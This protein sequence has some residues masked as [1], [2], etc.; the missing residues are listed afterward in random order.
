VVTGVAYKHGGF[1]SSF[2][3]FALSGN[4]SREFD[5]KQRI[6]LTSFY[7]VWSRASI[8]LDSIQKQNGKR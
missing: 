2:D 5:H 1:A 3:V 6:G 8:E 4:R 7:V